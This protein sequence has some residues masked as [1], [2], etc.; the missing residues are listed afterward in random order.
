MNADGPGLAARIERALGS[1]A[2]PWVV[3]ALTVVLFWWLNGS[4]NPEPWVYD[5]AA[6]V[7]Q[8][9]IFAGW[10][11]SVPGPPLPE[12]FEQFHVF[13]TP[14][15]V[16][17]YPPGH[18]LLMVPGIWLG[19]A[20]LV[21]LLASGASA[22]LLYVAGRRLGGGWSGLV[23]WLVWIS[24]PEMLLFGPSYM[25]QSTSTLAWLVAWWALLRWRDVPERTGPLAAFGVAAAVGAIVRPVTAIALLLPAGLWI[26]WTAWRRGRAR[27]VVVGVAAAVPILL[28]PFWWSFASSG[29]AFP[30]PYSEYSRVYAPWNMPG[31]TVDTA[32]PLRE[33]TPAMNKFRQQF[34]PQHEAHR[35]ES[36]TT[37]LGRRVEG[38]G[39]RFFGPRGR[40]WRW[41]L[42]VPFLVGVVVSPG[43]LRFGLGSA[44]VLVLAY[45]WMTAHPMWTIY[46]LE[47][48]PILALITALGVWRLAGWSSAAW[49]RSR[50]TPRLAATGTAAL[51]GL[52]ML[53]AAPGTWQ[54]F[55]RART[56]L[57][58]Y[59]APFAALTAAAA[60]IPGKAIVFVAPGPADDPYDS[61]VRNTPDPAA[62]R[63]WIVDD[64]GDDNGRLM[65]LAPDRSAYR[66]DPT[67]QTLEPY[68]A[69]SRVP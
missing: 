58:G 67:R 46:Y 40:H 36:L 43:P 2:A 52:G 5:E 35:T 15:L 50:G 22:A 63:V 8:A 54:R 11:W 49:A 66:Y 7:L 62:E 51:C 25:A 6:Y 61:F 21:P 45:L 32:A 47:V 26:L 27:P 34:L 57:D 12:F 38:I 65:A 42:L 30:T 1:R 19:A 13:V 4:L 29:Q 48:Y 18:A 23:A 20:S 56:A 53:I 9:R 37:M 69:E 55:S 33:P 14:R 10:H 59:R 44:V 16:P 28:L 31:F 64:R 60:S 39:V 17:K 3:A 68:R 24:A 41:L